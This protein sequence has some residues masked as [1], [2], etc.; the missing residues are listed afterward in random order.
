[1]R[2]NAP[3]GIILCL[4]AILLFYRL[5]L[6]SMW[7][8]ERITYLLAAHPFGEIVGIVQRDVH[9][10]LYYVLLHAWTRLPLPWQGIAALRAFSALWA[11]AATLLLDGLWTRRWKPGRRWLAVSLFA[12]SPCLLLYGRMARSYAM[13]TAL[14][15]LA[16]GLLWRWLRDPDSPVRDHLAAAAALVALLYTHYVPGIALLAGFTA[17]AWRPLGARRTGVFLAVGLAGYL[18]WILTLYQALR[19]WGQPGHFA[20]G[21][22]LTGN[23]FTEQF[24]KIGYGL[25]SLT[26]GES[27]WAVSLAL[28]PVALWL[29]WLGMRSCSGGGRLL[30][31]LGL[32]AGVGYLGTARWVSFPFVPAR[33]L[34]LLPVAILAMAQGIFRLRAPWRQVVAGAMTL[35]YLSSAALYFRGENYLNTGYSAPLREIGERLNREAAPGDIIL[36]DDYNTDD[37]VRYYF[38]G[39]TPSLTLRAGGEEEARARLAGAKAVWVI[40]NTRD[41]S[42]GHITSLLEA[43]GCAGRRRQDTLLH[44][45]APWQVSVMGLLGIARPAPRYVYQV[46]VCR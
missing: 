34:W 38:S 28:V 1:V 46:T 24:L 10:P 4:Q 32:A 39:R 42:P 9:P 17:A 23:A 26:I 15:I 20:A 27:F 3:L 25:V 40:R 33:L 7:M 35:S 13:Q 12:L 36:V 2:R 21:Y 11:L 22:A 41:I 14:A 43:E 18:P 5:D 29:V 19:S 44:P 45:Y 6:L 31:F 37:S 16:A 8:D 30:A